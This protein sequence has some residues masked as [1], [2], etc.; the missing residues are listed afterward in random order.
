MIGDFSATVG[1]YCCV[2]F[3]VSARTPALDEAEAFCRLNRPP[4]QEFFSDNPV[5]A[6][7]VRDFCTANG[8]FCY[9]R[10]MDAAVYISRNLAAVR[11][12]HSGTH[13]IRLP[14]PRRLVPLFKA[15][16]T[17]FSDRITVELETGEVAAFRMQ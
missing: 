16:E 2:F 6:A 5:S 4:F 8:A 7:E 10:D 17:I 15:G 9:C 13:T 14:E 1:Q 12:L 3:F 11:A